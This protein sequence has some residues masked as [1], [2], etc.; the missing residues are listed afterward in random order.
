[1]HGESC[2]NPL[3]PEV[4]I[5]SQSNDSNYQYHVL[6]FLRRKPYPEGP[7]TRYLRSLVP[8][9]I[10]SM[11]FGTRVLTYWVLGPSGL[12]TPC[13]DVLAVGNLRAWISA[14]DDSSTLKFSF[15]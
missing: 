10:P 6:Q 11:A 4:A 9:T 13:F 2:L 7:S 1:M 3:G 15:N 12:H 5:L 8:E 14:P